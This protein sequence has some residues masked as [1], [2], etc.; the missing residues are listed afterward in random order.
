MLRR[1][2]GLLGR[3]AWVTWVILLLSLPV[4]S[5]PFFPALEATGETLVRPLA[6]YPLIVLI[7]I[8]LLPHVVRGG[9]WPRVLLPLGVFL[10]AAALSTAMNLLWPEMSLRGQTPA[11]R[12]LRAGATLAAGVAFYLV[13]VRMAGREGGLAGSARWMT[14]GLAVATAWGLLQGSRLIW[15]WP[16][17]A[18][19]NAIQRLFSVRDMHRY[20]VTGFSYEPSWFADQLVGLAIPFLIAAPLAGFH[21]I[22]RG[23]KGRALEYALI[24]AEIVALLL[25][26]SRGGVSSLIVS[27]AFVALVLGVARWRRSRS[28]LAGQASPGGGARRAAL[29]VALAVAGVGLAVLGAASLVSRSDYF[30]L[31]WTRLWRIRNPTAYLVSVG[32]GTRLALMQASWDTFLERPWI[33]VGLGQSGFFILDRLPAWSY[34]QV[35]EV[36]LLYAPTSIALP[37]PKNL[38]ARLLSETGLAGSV[39]FAAFI[40]LLGA[41]SVSL[42]RRPEPLARYIGFAGC[43]SWAAALLAGFSLDSFALPTMWISMGIVTAGAARFLRRQGSPAGDSGEP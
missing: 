34:D 31:L 13:A 2:E 25:T 29:R 40:V 1:S 33:G 39:P 14:L 19:L 22:G 27:S 23:R 35:K 30:T 26:Y 21:L 3:A 37:N 16:H 20:R 8:D 10:A 5:F 7:V 41:A 42:A 15:N 11:S 12:A 6:F 18:P 32:A 43:M 38:W 28:R 9:R 36:A 4:T 24:A 17:Y